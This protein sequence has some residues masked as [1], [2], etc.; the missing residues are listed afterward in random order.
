M[1]VLR[2]TFREFSEDRCMQMAA[3]LAFYTMLSLVPLVLLV[4]TAASAVMGGAARE[5]FLYQAE[6]VVGK[7]GADELKELLN[8]GQKDRPF[9]LKA[10][11]NATERITRIAAMGLLIFSATSVMAQL[12]AS[13]NQV[14]EVE[15]DENQGGVKSFLVKRA[16]SLAMILGIAF[17]LLV[18]MLLTTALGIAGRWITDWLGISIGVQYLISEGTT[19]V[20]ITL[21]FAAMFKVLP[22]AQVPWKVTWSGAVVTAVLFTAGKFLIGLYL[23]HKDMGSSYGQAGSLVLLL[24]WIYYSSMIFLFGAE[25]TQVWARRWG[26]AI[27]P[28]KGAVRVVT[29][30]DRECPEP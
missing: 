5:R 10:E 16:L 6:Q 2:D 25:L 22:D 17:L 23:S 11:S 9:T 21:L 15:P 28:E 8:Q 7:Q 18:S 30:K 4:V 29:R 27:A 24:V 14:W 3:A 13:L 20:L 12:Q 1:G 26:W 19:F